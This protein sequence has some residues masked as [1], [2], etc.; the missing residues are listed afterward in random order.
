MK[1]YFI[2]QIIKWIFKFCVQVKAL[3]SELSDTQAE[4]QGDRDDY[5]ET[6]RNLQQQE[7]LLLQIIDKIQPTIRKD[8]NYA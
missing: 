4:F 8:S 6:I 3:T 5:L 7:K 1:N 2:A